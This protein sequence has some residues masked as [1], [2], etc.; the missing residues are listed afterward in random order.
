MHP[1]NML[2]ML[3]A[4]AGL[5]VV[6]EAAA[7]DLS[8]YDPTKSTCLAIQAA[9]QDE[10]EV[11]LRW[12]DPDGIARFDRYV[13]NGS[14]CGPLEQAVLRQVPSRDGDCSVKVC[15]SLPSSVDCPPIT[16]A[17]LDFRPR[18]FVT[19]AAASFTRQGLLWRATFVDPCGRTLG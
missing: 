5:L 18:P 8:Y 15:E 1:K 7:Q 13:A 6:A 17:E 10:G 9:I 16:L 11:I 19:N 12:D 2:G 3:L 14:Y 4:M